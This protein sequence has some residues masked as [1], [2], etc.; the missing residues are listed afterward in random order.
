MCIGET[1]CGKDSDEVFSYYTPAIVR[2]K[3]RKLG[4]SKL[5]FQVGAFLWIVGYNIILKKGW[6]KTTGHT[7]VVRISPLQPKINSKG[8]NK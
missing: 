8:E 1:C 2:I 7:A 3:D 4:L 5:F 6:A